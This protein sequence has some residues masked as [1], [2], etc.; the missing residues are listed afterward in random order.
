MLGDEGV[1]LMEVDGDAYSIPRLLAKN[2]R[3]WTFGE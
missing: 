1:I 3:A 2:L